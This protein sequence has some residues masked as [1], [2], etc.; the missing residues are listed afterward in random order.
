MRV[1][2]G[3]GESTILLGDADEVSVV[4]YNREG[5]RLAMWSK[6]GLEVMVLRDSS[7]VVILPRGKLPNRIYQG[8]GAGGLAWSRTNDKI[9]IAL[10][11]ERSKE[12]ELRTINSHGSSV[13]KIHSM[14]MAGGELPLP[15][16]YALNEPV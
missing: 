5:D 3:G 14:P 16:R 15:G 9:A 8:S 6:P 12:S 2:S 1:P 13:D 7:R 11:N 4:C 10:I